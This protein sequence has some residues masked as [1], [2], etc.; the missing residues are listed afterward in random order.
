MPT[1]SKVALSLLG[2]PVV[3]LGHRFLDGFR[4]ENIAILPN[5]RGET[6]LF[7]LAVTTRVMRGGAGSSEVAVEISQKQCHKA[8]EAP[9]LFFASELNRGQNKS[10]NWQKPRSRKPA[11]SRN[12]T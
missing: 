10:R 6:G 12:I 11:K 2:H 9:F 7:N 1:V 3:A 8:V 5:K 4:G